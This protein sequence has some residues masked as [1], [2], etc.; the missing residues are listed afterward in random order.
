VNQHPM[1]M[2]AMKALVS[3]IFPAHSVHIELVTEGVSTIVYRVVYQDEVFY[4]R[5]LPEENASF[6]PE[7]AVHTRLCQMQVK[8]PEVVHFEHSNEL[9]QRSIMVTTEIKGRPIGQST[10]LSQE[11]LHAILVEAGRDSR[12]SMAFP[13]L[14]LAG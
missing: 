1:D 8:V 10:F 2:P 11:A 13:L 12:T 3:Q 14:G 9:L 4:L 5:I 7:V 6:A